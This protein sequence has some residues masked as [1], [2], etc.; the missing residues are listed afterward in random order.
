M[1]ENKA[2]SEGIIKRI[3]KDIDYFHENVK[4]LG[5]LPI[6]YEKVVEQSKNYAKD[7]DSFLSKGDLY[8]AFACISYAHG[9]LDA[10]RELQKR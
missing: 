10:I 8:T 6:E 5:D 3:K 2:D 1:I 9:L 4:K 7:A